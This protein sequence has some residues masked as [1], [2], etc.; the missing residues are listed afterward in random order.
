MN[1]IDLTLSKSFRITERARMEFRASSYNFL[2]HPV[3]SAPDT[4]LGNA[5]FGRISGQANM[6]RQTEFAL[7]LLF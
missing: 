6:S 1:N 7:K 5:T 4:T 3:F 2:N